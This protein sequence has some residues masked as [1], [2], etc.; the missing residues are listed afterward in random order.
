MK[1]DIVPWAG[2]EPKIPHAMQFKKKERER[3][4]G[5]SIFTRET[6]NLNPE[7]R[8]PYATSPAIIHEL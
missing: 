1:G 7:L 6:R 2:I 3:E 5:A 4:R 8:H